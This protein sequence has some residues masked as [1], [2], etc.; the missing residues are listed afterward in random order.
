MRGTT[1][2]VVVLHGLLHLLGAA[3]GLG[4]ADIAQLSEPISTVMG[5][6]WLV[7]AALVI[8]AGVSLAVPSRWWWILGGTAAIVSQTLISTSWSDA[9]AGTAVNV[10]LMVAVVHEYAAHGPRSFRVGYQRRVAAALAEPTAHALVSEVDLVN[11]PALVAEYVRRCGAVGQPGVSNFRARIHGRIRGGVAKPWMV[12]TGEQVNTYGPRSS[13][14]FFIDATM[15]G[16]PV[17]VLHLFDRSATMRV[18]LCSLVTMVDARGPELDRAE[19]V[20]LF[21][22]MCVLAPAALVSAPISWQPIDGRRVRGSFTKG[23]HT[24]TAELVFDNDGDLVDFIS[25]DRSSSS[26]DGERF[27]HRRWSTPVGRYR[28]VGGR[29]VATF[30]EARWHAPLPEGEFAYLEFHVDNIT[31]N[32]DTMSGPH[33]SFRTVGPP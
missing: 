5:I 19:T 28:T 33:H 4:W 32:V 20:T 10:I 14:L 22:D 1:V 27:T 18:K 12:F 26:Q 2:V 3:K 8:G 25:D 7:G 24:V 21:N 31:Y 15:F 29:R 11:L 17:D 30:G 13:R 16:L 6:A 9:R 23:D